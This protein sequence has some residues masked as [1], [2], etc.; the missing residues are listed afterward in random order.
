MWRDFTYEQC[1]LKE[2]G[3]V[4]VT[5]GR[6]A[7]A[8]QEIEPAGSV[9]IAAVSQIMRKLIEP[10]ASVPMYV[11]PETKFEMSFNFGSMSNF[12]SDAGTVVSRS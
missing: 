1:H 11:L 9:G 5:L 7:G 2:M 4:R 3:G 8:R 12:Q 10:S 6:H